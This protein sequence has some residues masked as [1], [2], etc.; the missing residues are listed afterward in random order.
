[1]SKITIIEG[2][3][4]DKDQIRAYLVKGEKGDKGDKGQDGTGTKLSDLENDMGFMTETDATTLMESMLEDK[5]LSIYPIGSLYFTTTNVN[6]STYIGGYWEQVAVGQFLVGAGTGTDQNNVEKT[7]VVGENAG[8]YQH[9]HEAGSYYAMTNPTG[10]G[11]NYKNMHRA[12]TTDYAITG[13]GG[14]KGM[15]SNDNSNAGIQVDG[16]SGSSNNVVPSF[17]LYAWKRVNPPEEE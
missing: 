8:E 4:N 5:V 17:G 7:F 2:N 14:S 10:G 13:S 1:M 6:P 16:T 15:E 12:F 11:Q 3:S 9:T